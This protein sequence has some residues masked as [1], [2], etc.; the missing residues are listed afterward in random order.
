MIDYTDG[1]KLAEAD[2]KLRGQ[3]DFFGT[4]QSGAPELKFADIIKDINIIKQVRDDVE[5]ILMH[6]EE[7]KTDENYNVRKTLISMYKDSLS[8]FRI[9]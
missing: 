4:K 2:L 7:L 5:Y 9:G 6:D 8:Y 3:G 1:F